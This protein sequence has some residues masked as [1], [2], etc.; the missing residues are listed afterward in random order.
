MLVFLWAFPR[1]LPK[2]AAAFN[3]GRTEM[4][5]NTKNKIIAA[6]VVIVVAVVGYNLISSGGEEETAEPAAATE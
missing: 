5:M 4:E 1:G 2:Q 3:S 6:V